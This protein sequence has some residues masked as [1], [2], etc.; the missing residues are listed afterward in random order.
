MARDIF[1]N[2]RNTIRSDGTDSY[3]ALNDI[4]TLSS[5]AEVLE[6]YQSFTSGSNGVDYTSITTNAIMGEDA[7]MFA[8]LLKRS[9]A[10][11]IAIATI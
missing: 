1:E 9:S 11:R 10:A 4:S 8:S 6:I 3:L 5:N 7:F 2:G